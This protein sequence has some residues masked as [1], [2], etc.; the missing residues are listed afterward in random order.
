MN[1]LLAARN[2]SGASDESEFQLSALY[3]A[4]R[5]KWAK[6]CEEMR[7]LEMENNRIFIEAYG[8][9][10]ELTPEVPWQEITLTCNPFYRYGVKEVEKVSGGGD[11]AAGVCALPRVAELEERLKSD[12]VKELI[13]YGV[14]CMMGR[15]SL[16]KPGLILAGQG[17][18]VSDRWIVGREVVRGQ[19]IVGREVVRGA[20]I[21]YNV[22]IC[23]C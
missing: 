2:V 1:P 23:W 9:Q 11:G 4:V 6:D 14:G 5:E 20:W 17:A 3:A 21:V 8:L 10:D 19:W 13:S 18:Q 7:R 22:G 15:Y 12:T 16:A